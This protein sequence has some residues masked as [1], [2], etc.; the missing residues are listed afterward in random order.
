MEKSNDFFIAKESSISNQ[1]E[2]NEK[3]F[4]LKE[5]KSID[6]FNN[7]RNI[8]LT[9]SKP[10]VTN[11]KN[12]IIEFS[13]INKNLNKSFNTKSSKENIKKRNNANKIENLLRTF[14]MSFENEENFFIENLP[15]KKKKIRKS[16]KLNKN[17]KNE[18]KENEIKRKKDKDKFSI[19]KESEFD[20]A[21]DKHRIDYTDFNYQNNQSESN[22][23][24]R[25]FE[26]IEKNKELRN[27][28][29]EN[30]ESMR[31]L[32]KFNN[33]C[34]SLSEDEY[35]ILKKMDNQYFILTYTFKIFWDSL[36]IF[37][38]IESVL[39]TPLE[40]AFSDY[41]IFFL[42]YNDMI[43]E[44]IF[45]ID[46]LIQFITPFNDVNDNKVSLLKLI[47]KNYVKGWFLIDFFSCFPF[48]T[49]IYIMNFKMKN[50]SLEDYYSLKSIFKFSSFN[51]AFKWLKLFR[52]FK[53]FKFETLTDLTFI[54]NSKIIRVLKSAIIFL[55]LNHFSCCIWIYIGLL[56][57]YSSNN[58]II[59]A[60]ICDNCLFDI[61]IGSV[62]FN[63]TT[64]FSIGYGDIT[65]NNISEIIYNIILMMIGVILFSFA[66]SSLSSLFINMNHKEAKFRNNLDLLDK[67]NQEYKLPDLN[68]NKVKRFLLVE[69]NLNRT[70]IY[71]FLEC[72]PNRI[73]NEISLIMYR[74]LFKDHRFFKDQSQDFI[75]FVLPFLKSHKLVKDEVLFSFGEFVEE[76]YLVLKGCMALNLGPNFENFEIAKIKENEYFGDLLMNSKIQSPYEFNCKSNYCEVLVLNKNDFLKI[77]M[78]FKENVLNI[79][80]KSYIIFELIDKK[81]HT[82]IKLFSNEFSLENVKYLMRKLDIYVFNKGFEKFYYDNI[83]FENPYDFLINNDFKKTVKLLKG[84]KFKKIPIYKENKNFINLKKT[85]QNLESTKFKSKKDKRS[86]AV[87]RRNLNLSLN[88]NCSNGFLSQFESTSLRNQPIQ[89]SLST[90]KIDNKNL[91]KIE[92]NSNSLIT[93]NQLFPEV[94][95]NNNENQTSKKSVNN[96]EKS[97][98]KIQNS[99]FISSN[100]TNNT[101]FNKTKFTNLH[102]SIKSDQFTSD[103]SP[104]LANMSINENKTSKNQNFISSSNIKENF[105]KKTMKLPLAKSSIIINSLRSHSSNN[106]ITCNI[107]SKRNSN[108]IPISKMG[109]KSLFLPSR[110]ESNLI[111]SNLIEIL[112]KEILEE[113]IDLQ[114]DETELEEK[115]LK[116]LN[117]DKNN[118]NLKS[119]FQTIKNIKENSKFILNKINP[120]QIN[121]SKSNIN[122]QVTRSNEIIISKKKLKKNYD[123]D[124]F[125]IIENTSEFQ[126]LSFHKIFKDLKIELNS[127]FL[128]VNSVICCKSPE[129]F[130]IEFCKKL[131]RDSSKLLGKNKY[132]DGKIEY[133]SFG[134]KCETNHFKDLKK[135]SQCVKQFLELAPSQNSFNLK[136]LNFHS[137]K[138]NNLNSGN[139]NYLII[140]ENLK[141]INLGNKKLEVINFIKN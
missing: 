98:N 10:N 136:K 82:F 45:F 116:L 129:S 141:A 26:Q 110:K 75:F 95:Q 113:K 121:S 21:Y 32:F 111:K 1:N 107:F 87:E 79:M 37:L 133:Q 50:L 135:S 81:R 125:L 102:D 59:K 8:I 55:M 67:L 14:Q 137:L 15:F 71:Q 122:S 44:L 80:K 114:K 35:R 112:R 64:I 13:N 119:N 118:F 43:L 117:I 6:L 57:F 38:L 69:F 4:N 106:N 99:S 5:N 51:C 134:E 100:E 109:R 19:D 78:K 47:A 73:K 31:N 76:T 77:K 115:T 140:R 66:I 16:S 96:F 130:S 124:V 39:L 53:F 42:F 132:T 72:L 7:K 126:I 65:W 24:N 49:I 84:K 139:L 88:K 58:W 127:N 20:L 123:N 33:V 86:F 34:D 2:F 27:G 52:I 23:L 74:D 41:K 108:Q 90:V 36:N 40:I 60:N 30:L 128:I 9:V 18:E 56:K 22:N 61:Y 83:D 3:K 25:C 46:L 91:L 101:Y 85:S 28:N 12:E 17:K 89:N 63:L 68:Y 120:I 62:Y 48:N 138:N 104:R 92:G 54:S 97:L 131:E 94:F 29:K 105:N 70:D 11:E 93:F 103:I